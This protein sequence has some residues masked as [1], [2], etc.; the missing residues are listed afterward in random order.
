MEDAETILFQ[1][2]S[3]NNESVS[4]LLN[5]ADGLM[6]QMLRIHVLCTLNHGMDQIDPAILRPGRLRSHRHIGPLSREERREARAAA[7]TALQGRPGA[8][9][10][11]AGRDLPRQGLQAESPAPPGLSRRAQL[12][13]AARQGW[14][15]LPGLG[16]IFEQV[17]GLAVER[18]AQLLQGRKADR[19]RLAR[20][21]D[22]E[23][24]HGDADIFGFHAPIAP[25]RVAPRGNEPGM[26]PLILIP[27]LLCDGRLW[28]QTSEALADLA[29]C[30]VPDLAACDSIPAVAET[31]LSHAPREFALAGFSLGGLIA[32][33]VWSRAPERVSRLALLSVNAG[34]V[35]PA[36]QHSLHEAM[37]TV[38]SHGLEFYLREIFPRYVA[39]AN[40]GDE[41]V[42]KTFCAMGLDAG[43][44]GRGAADQG[45]AGLPGLRA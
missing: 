37:E 15:R 21:Q 20:L 6:G 7:P 13:A 41:A 42:W 10:L 26:T 31:I 44:E 45:V 8:R 22:G 9:A 38:A 17:A 19:A 23:I 40:A 18:L 35:L 29:R 32:L 27:G 33:E 30:E 1:R 16:S 36:V 12:D 5:I 24:L 14:P 43:P 28:S 3:D 11:H 39:P 4:A 2:R 34:G 25:P